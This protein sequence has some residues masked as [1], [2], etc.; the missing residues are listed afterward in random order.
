V[1]TVLCEGGPTLNGELARAGAIDELCLTVAPEL[2]GGSG[3]AGLLGRV[4]LEHPMG[5]DLVHELEEDDH[6]FLRYRTVGEWPPPAAD[7]AAAVGE[8]REETVQA[9]HRIVAGLDYP[10]LIVTAFDGKERSGCLVGFATQCSID[11]PR[12]LV[13]ISKQN[14]TSGVALGAD[15]LVVHVPSASPDDVEAA[16]LFGTTTGDQIDKF[17]RCQWHDGPGG[18]PVLDGIERWFAGSVM[19]RF[20]AGDHTAYL[21]MPIEGEAGDDWTGQLGFQAVKDLEPGHPA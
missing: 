3:G 11:P 8:E 18:A 13:C 6:L 17:E 4:H 2:V 16:E 15:V 14:H 1:A 10:M 12:Y 7:D 5:L 9:F 20:D 21:L 19:E